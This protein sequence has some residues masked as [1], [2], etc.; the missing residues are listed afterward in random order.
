MQGFFCK[1]AVFFS[2]WFVAM[3][4]VALFSISGA[5]KPHMRFSMIQVHTT[6]HHC[7]GQR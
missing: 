3:P 4:V 6:T 2:L 1:M 7:N 5:L